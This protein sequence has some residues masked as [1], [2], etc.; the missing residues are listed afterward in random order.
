MGEEE[1]REAK[2]GDSVR[3]R[4]KDVGSGSYIIRL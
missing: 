3:N 1:D 2:C 4:I